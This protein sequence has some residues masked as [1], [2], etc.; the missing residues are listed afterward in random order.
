MSMKSWKNM[1]KYRNSII[2]QSGFRIMSIKIGKNMNK[3]KN[4]LILNY[5]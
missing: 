5:I 3:Y 4:F 2:L 1:N